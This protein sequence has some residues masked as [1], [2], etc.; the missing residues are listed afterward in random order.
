M[1][2]PNLLYSL[3]ARRFYHRRYGGMTTVFPCGMGEM[4]AEDGTGTEVRV[5]GVPARN[6]LDGGF[7]PVR[8]DNKETEAVLCHAGFAGIL[9]SVTIGE[10]AID[11]SDPNLLF[12][13]VLNE[14][15]PVD[16][17]DGRGRGFPV[18]RFLVGHFTPGL[19]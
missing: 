11:G 13:E 17:E 8:F 16:R 3:L 1:A 15:D 19:Q 6:S 2:S 14:G 5:E 7:R 18:P 10:R 9:A 12:G 4:D